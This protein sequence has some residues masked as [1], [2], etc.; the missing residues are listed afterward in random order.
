MNHTA[1]SFANL[2][3]IKTKTVA[4][5]TTQHKKKLTAFGKLEYML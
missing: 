5:K 4:I 2:E 1:L 3:S